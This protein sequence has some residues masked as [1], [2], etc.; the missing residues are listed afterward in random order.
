MGHI[1][2]AY[3]NARLTEPRHFIHAGSIVSAVI[4]AEVLRRKSLARVL[5]SGPPPPW[6]SLLADIELRLRSGAAASVSKLSV[7]DADG[8]P[9]WHIL[10]RVD[11]AATDPVRAFVLDGPLKAIRDQLR[12]GNARGL[13]EDTDRA[14]ELLAPLSAARALQAQVDGW[15]WQMLGSLGTSLLNAVHCG[16]ASVP[17][18]SIYCLSRLSGLTS[19]ILKLEPLL[20]IRS[21][22]WYP[23]RDVVIIV[24]PHAPE[25]RDSAQ[26]L[27]NDAGPAITF[28]DG[29]QLHAWHGITVSRAVIEEP[30][31]I[32]A[33]DIDGERNVE[34]RRVLLE[35]FGV[36]RYLRDSGAQLVHHDDTGALYR[37]DFPDDE[38]LV[39]VRVRDASGDRREYWLRVAP[40][41]R[42]ARE[43]VAW[44]FGLTAAA[45]YPSVQT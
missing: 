11:P 4:I 37:R 10:S 40:R 41:V 42:T 13:L 15:A 18:F 21:T 16:H 6:R 25:R 29:A 7:P 24:A 30:D 1:R 36:E 38:P 45:Y 27:H 22:H 3:H 14:V 39:V 34:V 44:T 23:M 31:N 17:L 5:G 2:R 19:E 35:R 12:G 8:L 26:R 32:R 33:Q 20:A 9:R 28:S 43:A